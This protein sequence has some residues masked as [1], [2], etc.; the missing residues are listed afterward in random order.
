MDF[1]VDLPESNDNTVIWTIIDLFSKQA[2]FVP[3]TGLP[4]ARKLAKLFIQHVY[5]LHGVPRHI[6]SDGVQFTARF[7]RHFIQAIGSTQ[8]LSSAFRPSTNG[9][10][11]RANAMVERYLRSYV[12]YQQTD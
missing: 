10:A 6:L 2:H 4:L 7:W 8:R 1:V 9:A 5:R 11:E 12:S 3:C